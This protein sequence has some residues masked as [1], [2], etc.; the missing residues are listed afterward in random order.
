MSANNRDAL[1]VAGHTVLSGDPAGDPCRTTPG[2]SAARL[3][4]RVIVAVSDIG[5]S[6]AALRRL[7]RSLRG[8][9]VEI[10][11][12]HCDAV[13]DAID[14][15]TAEWV[16]VFRADGGYRPD[17]VA[18]LLDAVGESDIV[19]ASRF[20]AST[21]LPG[22][23]DRSGPRV[24]DGAGRLAAAVFPVR[25]RGCTDPF[26]GAFAMRRSAAAGCRSRDLTTVLGVLVR[27]SGLIREIPARGDAVVPAGGRVVP[28]GWDAVRQIA[29][30]RMGTLGW[31]GRAAV[32]GLV[33][34]SGVI[35]NLAAIALLVS[36]GIG[37]AV[38]AVLAIEV[39]VLWNFAGS[40]LLVWRHARSGRSRTARFCR[41]WVIAQSDVAR[42]PFVILLVAELGL[43]VEM[44]TVVTLVAAFLLR[45]ALAD[46]LVYGHPA[47]RPTES[48]APPT[49]ATT[50]DAV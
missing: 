10:V 50:A 32:F 11:V 38:A 29:R 12:R 7:H 17:I 37:Y 2:P 36:A 31:T 35:P 23:A 18:R 30:L 6:L 40:E 3:D 8:R 14:R 39:A 41:F 25:L 5:Y 43:G 44:A 47:P 24:A 46:R 27:S 16:V 28:R 15:S 33:G 9:D 45:F 4:A 34:L 13:A 48:A 1:P 49:I 20:C 26:S 19:S 42:I 21:L 22:D